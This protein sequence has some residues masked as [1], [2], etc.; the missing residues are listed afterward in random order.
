MVRRCCS[1]HAAQ[2]NALT[3]A[4]E[5]KLPLIAIGARQALAHARAHACTRTRAHAGS[6]AGTHA[7]TGAH[8]SPAWPKLPSPIRALGTALAV[9]G[10][11]GDELGWQPG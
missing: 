8:I 10:A 7:R 11:T 4:R 6:D 3:I 5:K 2:R 1:H 9:I